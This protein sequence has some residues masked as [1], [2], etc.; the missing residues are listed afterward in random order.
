MFYI[1]R[2]NKEAGRIELVIESI[3]LFWKKRGHIDS[4]VLSVKQQFTED[5][6][7]SEGDK[8]TSLLTN[9]QIT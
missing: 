2:K 8:L 9:L 6:C 3:M 1:I 5:D 4:A 7:V